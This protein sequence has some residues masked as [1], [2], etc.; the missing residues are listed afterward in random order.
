M[1]VNSFQKK[2]KCSG[3]LTTHLIIKVASVRTL[4]VVRGR[5]SEFLLI[6][7]LNNLF[8]CLFLRSVGKLLS[9]L[10]TVHEHTNEMEWLLKKYVVNELMHKTAFMKKNAKRHAKYVERKVPVGELDSLA[11]IVFF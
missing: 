8:G 2:K 6:I 5:S 10:A 4:A 9:L 11:A 7:A 1:N 3:V